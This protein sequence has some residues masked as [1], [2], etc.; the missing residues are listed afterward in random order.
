MNI[1]LA[2][3]PREGARSPWLGCGASGMWTDY[4]DAMI[5]G[6]LDFIAD[7]D[8]AYWMKPIGGGVYDPERIPSV[9][10]NFR[11]DTNEVLGIVSDQY[12]VVQNDEAFSLVQPFVDAGGI[13]TN[14][15]H[16]EQGLM[17][18]VLHLDDKQFLGDNYSFDIMCTNS[19][20]GKFPLGLMMTPLRIY[21]QN[22]YR[23]LKKND[24]ILML[25]HGSNISDRILKASEAVALVDGYADT[26]GRQ[27]ETAAGITKSENQINALIA[28]LFPY[29]KEDAKRYVTS[30]QRIDDMREGF[31]YRY[32]MAPDND[33]YRGS[34]LGFLNAYYDFLS[35]GESMRN[36]P[37]NLDDR[38][39]SN[40]V[41][42]MSVDTKLIAEAMR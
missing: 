27:L 3:Q 1:T 8:E 42:G 32:Y 2:Q 40:L 30:K 12:G 10:V 28:M 38:R 16:T 5:A 36:M 4:Q 25:R 31:Y 22:L 19:F 34:A 18:M 14:A 24:S 11:T 9:H 29:P 17:F 35:H 15:G 33:N 20:N 26:F 6:D 37:G 13:I 41:S 21:C 39:L 7:N 23:K